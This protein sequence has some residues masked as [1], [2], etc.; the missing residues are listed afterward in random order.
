MNGLSRGGDDLKRD[1]DLARG[2]RS[3][4]R[5]FG[6]KPPSVPSTLRDFAGVDR[7]VRY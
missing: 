1:S 2:R 5:Q 6:T 4:R 7:R 3:S